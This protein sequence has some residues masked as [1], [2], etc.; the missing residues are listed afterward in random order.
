MTVK[1][2]AETLMALQSVG[3]WMVQHSTGGDLGTEMSRVLCIP[4]TMD[5][6]H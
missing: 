1:W 4:Q 5:S 6:T 2:Y 3:T